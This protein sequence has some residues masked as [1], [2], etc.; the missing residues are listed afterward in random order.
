MQ[1]YFGPDT[2]KNR[3]FFKSYGAVFLIVIAFFGGWYVGNGRS[4][5]ASGNTESG[6]VKNAGL[7][8]GDY[9]KT[10]P[11]FQIFWDVWEDIQEEYVDQPVKESDLFYGAMRGLLSSI[12]DPYS[13]FYDPKLASE[14]NAELS[15]EFS[16]IG[17]EVGMKNDMLVVIAPL[18]GSPGDQ[19]GLRAGDKIIAIEGEDTTFMTLDEAVSRIRGEEGTDVTL[20]ILGKN[21]EIR[22]VVITRQKIEHT[23]LRWEYLDNGIVHIKFSTFDQDAENQLNKFIREIQQRN[24]VKGLILDLRNNPGGFLETAI[25]TASEWVEQGIILRERD[26]QGEERQH[27][28]RG[29]ARLSDY[30]TVVL[31]NEG[32]ASASEIVAGALQDYDLATVVGI[33]TFG[34][35][36]VQKYENLEDGSS[37]RLTVAKWYTPL[38]RA[39]NEVGIVP[40][41]EVDLTEEDFNND[42]DP[43]MEKAMELLGQ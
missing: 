9:A 18:D 25:E 24:D 36:S 17:V 19:A 27:H 40:D 33:T 43:Q 10:A 42:R 14:F 34:K 12:D 37:F 15:G 6:E 28:A 2:T 21:E 5:S 16:G 13:E 22:E 38:E 23:G 30:P 20:V 41:I 8:A 4:T 11:D 3:S 7:I 1:R 31:V 29:R 26:N 32:S 35:G 39:I